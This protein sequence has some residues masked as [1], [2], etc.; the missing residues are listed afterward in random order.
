MLKAL[1]LATCLASLSA[2]G[3]LAQSKGAFEPWASKTDL[4]GIPKHHV[5]DVTT[6]PYT[7]DITQGGTM[8]GTMCTTLPAQK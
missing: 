2:V 3:A 8:D 4:T 6:E 5:Q 1:T 7:Y